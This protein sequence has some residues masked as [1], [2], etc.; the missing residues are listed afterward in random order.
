MSIEIKVVS[1]ASFVCAFIRVVVISLAVFTVWFTMSMNCYDVPLLGNGYLEVHILGYRI[2]PV[3]KHLTP[4]TQLTTSWTPRTFY[5]S[6]IKIKFI[7]DVTYLSEIICAVLLQLKL[8]TP[9]IYGG[10]LRVP[11]EK[12]LVTILRQV[13][14][15]L[16]VNVANR[17]N[18]ILQY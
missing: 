9:P 4:L 11:A 10:Y 12:R 5:D 17:E 16:L 1:C 8:L 6:L 15:L 2:V 18:I 13:N 7:R 14:T 3:N